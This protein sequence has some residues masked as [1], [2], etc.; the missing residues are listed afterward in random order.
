MGGH[1]YGLVHIDDILVTN[2][3]PCSTIPP[4]ASVTT[5]QPPILTTTPPGKTVCAEA[6]S[7]LEP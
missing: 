6:I 7:L 3:S 5:T 1:N 2:N 4:D